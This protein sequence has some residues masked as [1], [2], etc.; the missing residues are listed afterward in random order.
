MTIL[1]AIYKII[2]KFATQKLD[3]DKENN[4]IYRSDAYGR[5]PASPKYRNKQTSIGC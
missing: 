1:E 4:T 2:C 3:Y 5:E